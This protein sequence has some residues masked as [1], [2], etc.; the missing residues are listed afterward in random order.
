M[1]KSIC[2]ANCSECAMKNVCKGCAETNGCPFGKQCFIAKYINLGGKEAFEQL[3][4]KLIEEFNSLGIDG[5]PK[6]D[7]LNA[8]VGSFVNLEYTLPGGQKVKF[9]DDESIYLGNQLECLFNSDTCFGVIAGM[10]FLL[11][12]TYKEGGTHPEII[13]YKKR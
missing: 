11:V 5:M 9:L 8:L 13:A 7:R 12:C 2:S 4:E 1:C 3:K 6:L 10:D